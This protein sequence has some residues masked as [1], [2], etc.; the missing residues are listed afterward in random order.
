MSRG[1]ISL[2]SLFTT[3]LAY[4]TCF[5]VYGSSHALYNLPKSSFMCEHVCLSTLWVKN[6]AT[7]FLPP[8]S[9]DADWV[10]KIVSETLLWLL[11]I[12][13]E[14][15]MPSGTSNDSKNL[16]EAVLLQ[17]D[18]STHLSVEILQLPIIPKFKDVSGLWLR[19]HKWQFALPMQ[20]HH[21]ANECTE[22]ISLALAIIEIF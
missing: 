6:R 18:C 22:L 2:R 11:L 9:F 3:T 13:R 19:L 8:T 21:I 15:C 7:T 20:N 16:Q 10:S 14:Q 17:R 5:D 12:K 4:L 1:K